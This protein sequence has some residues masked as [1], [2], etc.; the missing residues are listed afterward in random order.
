MKTQ[1]MAKDVIFS[2]DL[3]DYMEII[4]GFI[5]EKKGSWKK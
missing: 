1:M 2:A 3:N 4:A 5:P